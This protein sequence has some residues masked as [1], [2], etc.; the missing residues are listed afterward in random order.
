MDEEVRV[1]DAVQE[2]EVL[3]VQRV[4]LGL[5]IHREFPNDDLLVNSRRYQNA[6]SYS[7]YLAQRK[8]ALN[9]FKAPFLANEILTFRF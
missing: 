3:R 2:S 9:P 8:S 7:V 6:E 4:L 1:R 5:W